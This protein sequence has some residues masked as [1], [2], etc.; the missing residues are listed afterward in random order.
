MIVSS[1]TPPLAEGHDQVYRLTA[2]GKEAKP[3]TRYFLSAYETS[4]WSRRLAESG[5]ATSAAVAPA[6]AFTEL[7]HEE[8]RRL[9]LAEQEAAHPAE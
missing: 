5:Y 2:Y 8:L 6:S 4:V 7:D 3:E 1:Q 9:G